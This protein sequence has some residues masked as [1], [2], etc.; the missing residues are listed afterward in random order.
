MKRFLLAAT[1]TIVMFAFGAAAQA[2][3]NAK[4]PHL[5]GSSASLNNAK[6]QP[7]NY[8][9][10]VHVMGQEV[11]ALMVESQDAVRLSQNI[12]VFDQSNKPVA[13][14]VSMNGQTATIAFAQPVKPDT[15]L[16]V[17]L[18]NVQN[19]RAMPTVLFSV[20]SQIVGLNSE[21]ALG[22]IQARTYY[23]RF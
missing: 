13:A 4:V 15:I 6:F 22:T 2:S 21:I 7:G 19:P 8:S 11:S 23:G 3:S 14:T 18:R 12:T 17:D 1:A 16:R 5:A 10:K 9:L 20:S